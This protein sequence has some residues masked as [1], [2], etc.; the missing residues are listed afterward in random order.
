[1]ACRK[2]RKGKNFDKIN[3]YNPPPISNITNGKPQINEA[4]SE[5]A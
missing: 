4:N 1:M 5:I 2:N 3:K